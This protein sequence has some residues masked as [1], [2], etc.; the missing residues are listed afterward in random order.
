MSTVKNKLHS[1]AGI[2]SIALCVIWIFLLQFF[3]RQLFFV[4]EGDAADYLAI[5]FTILLFSTLMSGLIL[6]IIWLKRLS[7]Q[8]STAHRAIAWISVITVSLGVILW[9][10][11]ATYVTANLITQ[12]Q[13]HL[14]YQECLKVQDKASA[15]HEPC[16]DPDKIDID[17]RNLR[18]GN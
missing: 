16:N 10:F 13:A 11:L 4:L 1:I 12:A 14:K 17:L 2:L 18:Y 8:A 3:T 7:S 15:E 6:N 9:V 5:A